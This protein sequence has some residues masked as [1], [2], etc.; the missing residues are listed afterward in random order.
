MAIEII[1]L[2]IVGLIVIYYLRKEKEKDDN[3]F[4]EPRKYN[5]KELAILNHNKSIYEPIPNDNRFP[6][7]KRDG[8]ELEDVAFTATE[9]VY[10]NPI[11]TKEQIGKIKIG[12]LVKLLF[13][14]NDGY[15]ERMWVEVIEHND[16]F[17]KGLL[18][19]DA[20]GLEDLNE[21]KTI[22]FHSNNIYDIDSG[23]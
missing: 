14:D 19:N 23:E 8:F 11:P 9:I 20:I 13:T 2:V 4:G 15:V 12:D 17:F 22:Y 7:I 18:R 3:Y 6:S 10:N 16:N 1:S 21:G 5:Q